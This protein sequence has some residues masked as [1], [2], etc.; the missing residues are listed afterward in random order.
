MIL[1]RM[2]PSTVQ[3]LIKLENLKVTEL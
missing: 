1:V 3:K 2:L